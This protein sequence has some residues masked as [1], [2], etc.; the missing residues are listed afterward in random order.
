MDADLLFLG[1]LG[2][3]MHGAFPTCFEF[4]FGKSAGPLTS[5]RLA[6]LILPPR[7]AFCA[8][9]S[10][11]PGVASLQPLQFTD[12]TSPAGLRCEQSRFIAAAVPARISQWMRI[13]VPLRAV[14][15]QQRVSSV[16]VQRIVEAGF[17]QIGTLSA[18]HGGNVGEFQLCGTGRRSALGFSS[19]S[20]D[21]FFAT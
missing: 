6:S 9:T 18:G 12:G 11:P 8:V 5:E 13:S 17:A 19:W 20:L 14:A 10:L 7:F 2:Y 4:E 3:A 15:W 21:P 1:G 16:P